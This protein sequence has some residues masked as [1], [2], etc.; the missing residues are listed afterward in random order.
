[1]VGL[2]LSLTCSVIETDPLPIISYQWLRGESLV[3]STS[4]LRF[5]AL[6]LSD[7]G[8][9]KCVVIIRSDRLG[10][11]SVNSTYDVEFQSEPHE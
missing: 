10:E 3:A 6:F 5:E 4:V 9:Y 2:G 8:Q 11:L 1:M 7:A